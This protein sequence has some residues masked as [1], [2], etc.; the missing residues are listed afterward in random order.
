MFLHLRF[1]GYGR[2]EWTDSAVR[3]YVVDAGPL[4]P[5]LHKLVR[6][7]YHDPQQA[8]GGDAVGRLRRPG[9]ADRPAARAGGAGRD[10]AGPGRHRDHGDPGHRRRA[11]WSAGPTSTCWRCGWS[12]ARSSHDRAVAELTSWYGRSSSEP[13]PAVTQLEVEPAPVSQVAERAIADHRGRCDLPFSGSTSRGEHA[14]GDERDVEQRVVEREHP[15]AELVGDPLGDQGVDADLDAL[16]GQARAAPRPA[17]RL[18]P[19][20][21]PQHQLD[22]AGAEQQPPGQRVKPSRRAATGSARAARP[23][24]IA[25]AGHH[26]AEPGQA[27]PERRR[28]R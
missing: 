10:P 14:G 4:L 21:Q 16:R 12:T 15:A 1:Y 26:L 7:D 28:G 5:R 2:G 11:R 23:P 24:P 9:A 3:R 19:E 22:H 20:R 25:I 18:Q 27:G 13:T 6:S 8:Q 17:A